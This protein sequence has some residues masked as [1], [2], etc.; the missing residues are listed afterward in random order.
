MSVRWEAVG[1]S[2]G[3]ESGGM[4]V[5][6]VATKRRS[7][8]LVIHGHIIGMPHAKEGCTVGSPLDKP[9]VEGPHIGLSVIVG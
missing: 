3:L 6:R 1:S 9:A 2:W 8:L 5:G 7:G 4:T